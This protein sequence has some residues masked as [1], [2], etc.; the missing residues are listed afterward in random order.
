MWIRYNGSI[1]VDWFDHVVMWDNSG[2]PSCSS[3]G[4]SVVVASSIGVNTDRVFIVAPAVVVTEIAAV[5]AIATGVVIAV[6]ATTAT[7]AAATAT[8]TTP[9]A[10]ATAIVVGRYSICW[11]C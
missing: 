1:N 6:T 3:L 9:T 5:A 7:T 10:T 4:S 2:S 11:T 8:G